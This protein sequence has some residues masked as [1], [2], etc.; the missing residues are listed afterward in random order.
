MIK[1]HLSRIMGEKRINIADLSR[2]TGLHRNGIAKLYN[3]ETDG[4]K[5]DTLNRICEALDCEIQDII[6]F[7]K[8]E[9]DHL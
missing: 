9:K 5:F 1:I 3:E 4:V 8:D 6:E 7:I 2:L